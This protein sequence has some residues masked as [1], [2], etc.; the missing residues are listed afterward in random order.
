MES[1]QDPWT[2]HTVEQLCFV[3]PL[4]IRFTPPGEDP[5]HVVELGSQATELCLKDLVDAVYA[6]GLQPCPAGAP[7]M[8]T[9]SLETGMEWPGGSNGEYHGMQWFC[10]LAY[11]DQ[12]SLWQLNYTFVH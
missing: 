3:G 8:M 11:D 4:R 9:E 5:E 7:D 6:W 1:P 12:S 2:S 10:G